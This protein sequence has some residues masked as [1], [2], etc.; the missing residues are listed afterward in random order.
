MQHSKAIVAAVVLIGIFLPSRAA[1]PH[2]T[3]AAPQIN[4]AKAAPLELRDAPAPIKTS[5][6]DAGERGRIAMC[7][8]LAAVRGVGARTSGADYA[9]QNRV[10]ELSF[11]LCMSGRPA[12][13]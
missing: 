1:S 13:E 12:R 9:T 5:L 2:A 8:N 7:A 6:T 11:I 4:P 10:L 3:A